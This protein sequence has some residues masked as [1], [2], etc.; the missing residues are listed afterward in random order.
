[1]SRIPVE[2]VVEGL[3]ALSNGDG[4]FISMNDDR[5]LTSMNDNRSECVHE[6]PMED[7]ICDSSLAHRNEAPEDLGKI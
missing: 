2:H 4:I 3:C 1:M 5:I 6:T 7:D